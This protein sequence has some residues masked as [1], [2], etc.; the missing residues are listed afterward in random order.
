M[1]Y[2]RVVLI[3]GVFLV[4]SLL[5]YLG[6]PDDGVDVTSGA[7]PVG[8]IVLPEKER[9]DV[10]AKLRQAKSNTNLAKRQQ[11]QVCQHLFN[12]RLDVLCFII[13]LR[14]W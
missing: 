12:S 3:G 13:I 2:A 8:D 1:N 7:T 9:W 14:R 4:V 5:Y 10:R 6:N 11:D